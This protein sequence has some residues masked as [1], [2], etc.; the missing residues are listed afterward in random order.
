MLAEP[1]ATHE[2]QRIVPHEYFVI[3]KQISGEANYVK[4]LKKIFAAWDGKKFPSTGRVDFI[5]EPTEKLIN[6]GWEIGC[7]GVEIKSSFAIENKAG[8]AITQLLDYQ[9]CTYQLRGKTTEL[10]MIFLF[11]YRKTYHEI[12]SIM[13]Q[14]GL[15][16][17][18]HL[19][20]YDKVFQLLQ[21]NSN[22]P[23]FSLLSNGEIEIRKPR[24]GK[25]F[26]HR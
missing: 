1:E 23:V 19:P 12:A 20:K 14:E 26:G 22:E 10:S 6:K 13:Q 25:K 17:V 18:R 24:F 5:L 4:K 8:R 21:P 9:S 11:P 2:F 16:F 15:G 3:H 7:I